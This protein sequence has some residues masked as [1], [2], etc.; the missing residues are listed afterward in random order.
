MDND[1]L[2]LSNI[3]G[4]GVLAT[5]IVIGTEISTYSTM[6]V[7]MDSKN[8]CEAIRK[9]NFDYIRNVSPFAFPKNNQIKIS[10]DTDGDDYSEIEII[11][12]PVVKRMIFQFKKL[13]KMNFS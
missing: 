2:R 8:P 5:S 3:I 9:N 7:A 6:L 1:K 11:E 4:V 10:V 12:V 13:V